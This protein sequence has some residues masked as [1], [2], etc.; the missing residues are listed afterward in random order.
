MEYIL[1]HGSVESFDK[2]DEK[3]IRKNES[4]AC[5]NG[6]WFT[7]DE[8]ASPAWINPKFRKTCKITI[9]NPAP[10]D[11][12]N[13]LYKYLRTETDDCSCTIIRNKLITMG[14]DGVIFDDVPYINEE[15]LKANGYFEYSTVRGSKYKLVVN[16]EYNGLDLYSIN[17]F[18]REEIITGYDDVEDFLSLQETTIVAFKSEQIEI[19]E[20][21]SVKW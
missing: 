9:K 18:G 19:L 11:I 21:I 16:E 10:H 8:S 12:I 7:S 6:F 13:K 5:Y 17:K 2:F 14:Y 15:E 4:D 1:Y 3:K 20:E